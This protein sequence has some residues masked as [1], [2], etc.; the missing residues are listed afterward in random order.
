MMP[1]P[2][3]LGPLILAVAALAA[4]PPGD[5]DAP[6]A[7]RP[8]ELI[9]DNPTF[10]HLSFR[11]PVR[12]DADGDASLEVA[13]REAGAEEWR[14]TLPFKR[15]AERQ[16]VKLFAGSILN[17]RPGTAYE[18]RL[19]LDDPDG[20]GASTVVSV[21]TREI[22]AAD[23]AG[24]RT[25][26]VYPDDY[27]GDRQEPRLP[28]LHAAFREARAG[29]LVLVHAGVHTGPF[30]VSAGGTRE[31][32]VV[33]RGAG[34]GEA[35]LAIPPGETLP[36]VS[37]VHGADYVHLEGLT[38]EGSWIRGGTTTGWVIRG[39]LILGGVVTGRHDWYVTDNVIVGRYAQW[40]RRVPVPAGNG[41]RVFGKGHVL[42]HNRISYHWDGITTYWPDRELE[43]AFARR[44]FQ[45]AI[46]IEDN[47]IFACADDAIEVDG[48]NTNVRV[49]RNRIMSG[50]MGI[51]L[52]ETR[53]GPVYVTHNVLSNLRNNAWKIFAGPHHLWILHNT[54]ASRVYPW[55]P[56]AATYGIWDSVVL[57]NVFASEAGEFSVR[58]DTGSVF[59]HNAYL[60][61]GNGRLAKWAPAA[62]GPWRSVGSLEELARATGHEAHGRLLDVERDFAGPVIFDVE[63]DYEPTAVDLRPSAES[64]AI[65][66]GR[67]IPTV[68]EGHLGAAPDIGA[69]EHGAAEHRY[70]PRGAFPRGAHTTMAPIGLTEL[71]MKEHIVLFL[72]VNNISVFEIAGYC[73]LAGFGIGI[74]ASFL[75]SRWRRPRRA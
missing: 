52:Q 57:N 12:G 67:A 21:A 69:Y 30:E 42:S 27:A 10:R 55:Q 35:I 73:A 34:D 5:P 40:R 58:S 47:L 17:L 70:G 6:E 46:D 31:S 23:L 50:A 59:D 33:Y 49:M 9:V 60:D 36:L 56:N 63:R 39:C 4:A 66:G 19:D 61:H 20:G 11:W 75:W 54:S 28:D 22:P 2:R 38:L 45:H 41:I 13:Y 65:D 71:T 51:S 29:D 16:G 7:A 53:P 64:A 62:A 48:I 14:P 68:N 26:H 25:L 32:P 43:W 24:A 72:D 1:S 37:G 15:V 18:V 44:G 74:L 8:E 3:V